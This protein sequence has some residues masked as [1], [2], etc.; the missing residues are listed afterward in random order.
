MTEELIEKLNGMGLTPRS[1]SGRY[2]Y[3]KYCVAVAVPHPS[4]YNLPSGW[5]TDNLG[6]SYIVYWPDVNWKEERE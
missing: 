3:G 2:M 6:L 5:R 1:Y 4:D